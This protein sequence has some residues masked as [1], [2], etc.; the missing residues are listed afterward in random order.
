MILC[1]NRERARAQTTNESLQM[2]R[3][4]SSAV[5]RFENENGKKNKKIYIMKSHEILLPRRREITCA[6][7]RID[8]NI[9]FKVGALAAHARDLYNINILLL[10]R[11]ALFTPVRSR[12][13]YAIKFFTHSRRRR[14]KYIICTGTRPMRHAYIIYIGTRR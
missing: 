9:I 14:I 8:N 6:P 10:T 13:H 11:G 2:Q 4:S 12:T 1:C 3:I 7:R 5:W